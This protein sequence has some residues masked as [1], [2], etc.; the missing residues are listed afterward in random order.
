[1]VLHVLVWLTFSTAVTWAFQSHHECR[2]AMVAAGATWA[3]TIHTEAQMHWVA[4][5]VADS[6]VTLH[7]RLNH[8]MIRNA[9]ALAV[10]HALAHNTRLLSVDLTWNAIG[11]EGVLALASA[12]LRN[13]LSAL[14]T[15]LLPVRLPT[16]HVYGGGLRRCLAPSSNRIGV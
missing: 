9:G 15:I 6:D 7:L 5:N 16:T 8:Q 10:A 13:P 1:M 14:T 3:P 4:E 2:V 11:D 12:L